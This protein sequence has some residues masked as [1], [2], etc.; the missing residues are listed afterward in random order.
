M[1]G[2]AVG[3]SAGALTGGAAGKACDPGLGF[4]F[5]VLGF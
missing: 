1:C 3:G 5:R 4:G 2:A